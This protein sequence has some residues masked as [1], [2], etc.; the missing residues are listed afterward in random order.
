MREVIIFLFLCLILFLPLVAE[1]IDELSKGVRQRRQER[2]EERRLARKRRREE[3]IL[4]KGNPKALT[5]K[6]SISE[7]DIIFIR[8][9]AYD[10]I[11]RRCNQLSRDG[12]VTYFSTEDIE[13]IVT[14]LKN[15]K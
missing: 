3:R 2:R 12:E 6:E 15:R 8:N 14:N 10:E 7:E 11:V 4:S 9:S 5:D 13:E 1:D